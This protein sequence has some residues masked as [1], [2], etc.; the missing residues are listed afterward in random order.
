MSS[1]LPLTELQARLPEI[2]GQMLPGQKL[3]VTGVD[4]H[5]RWHAG[6]RPAAAKDAPPTWKC[7]G[8]IGHCG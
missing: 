3:F 6:Q 2:L 4:G 1:F 8:Q 7:G 5:N